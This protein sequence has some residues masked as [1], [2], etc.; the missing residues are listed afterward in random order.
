MT[1]STAIATER[2][3]E[4]ESKSFIVMSPIQGGGTGFNVELRTTLPVGREITRRVYAE[5]ILFA[6][7]RVAWLM[8]QVPGVWQHNPTVE[9]AT[10]VITINEVIEGVI[11]VLADGVRIGDVIREDRPDSS[12]WYRWTA[13]ID[14]TPHTTWMLTGEDGG[15]LYFDTPESAAQA[16]VAAVPTLATNA[17]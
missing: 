17:S 12:G 3:F 13:H 14:K 16:V 10:P 9:S 5:T 7:E 1:T 8:E 2:W 11:D 15:A 4:P 6:A